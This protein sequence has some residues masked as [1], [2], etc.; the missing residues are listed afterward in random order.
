M[1]KKKL[2]S[3]MKD[4]DSVLFLPWNLLLVQVLLNFARAILDVNAKIE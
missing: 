1:Q 3:F 2:L 4:K